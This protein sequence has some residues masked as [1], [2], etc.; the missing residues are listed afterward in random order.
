LAADSGI[1]EAQIIMASSYYNGNNSMKQDYVKA[2]EYFKLAVEQGN[3]RAIQDYAFMLSR[4]HGVTRDVPKA[5][6]LLRAN[7]TSGSIELKLLYGI[8]LAEHDK[9]EITKAYTYIIQAVV[10][11]ILRAEYMLGSKLY[12]DEK[13]VE[14]IEWLTKAA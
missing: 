9:K 14:A 7:L 13:Y 1:S 3:I 5:L 6:E 10:H 4:G 12:E 2:V 8:I 11:G